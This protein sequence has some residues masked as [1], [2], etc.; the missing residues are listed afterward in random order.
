[1]EWSREWPTESG[2]YWFWGWF[3]K[4][5]YDGRGNEPKKMHLVECRKIQNGFLYITHG[6]FI[7][8]EEGAIGQWLPATRPTPPGDNQGE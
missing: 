5:Q 3:W 2:F 4:S 8:Q 6:H 1:M 7:Y